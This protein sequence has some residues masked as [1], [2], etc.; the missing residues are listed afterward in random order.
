[1]NLTSSY[2]L[3]AAVALAAYT[4]VP[5]FTKAAT[6]GIPSNTVAFWANAILAVLAL[7]VVLVS[8]DPIVG[9]LDHPK[10]PYM[11]AGGLCL[12]VGIIS[13]YRAL[14]LGPVS[15][16]V[17]VFGL[18]LVTSPL[19]GAVLLDEPL[20]LRKAAGVVIALVGVYLATSG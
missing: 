19:V 8:D 1:M 6:D 13:Y 16:V 4:F 20:T 15:I 12:A 18:F 3:W 7:G 2:L 5:V 9:A 11:L 10:A 14:S 17:P